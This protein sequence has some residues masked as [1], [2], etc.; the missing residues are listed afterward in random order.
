M[1]TSICYKTL[2]KI[3][4]REKMKRGEYK[5]KPRVTIPLVASYA[6]MLDKIK[7]TGHHWAPTE[8]GWAQERIT[9]AQYLSRFSPGERAEILGYSK[10][11]QELVSLEVPTPSAPAHN[12]KGQTKLM[13]ML[14]A[15]SPA[16][17]EQ[18]LRE[19]LQKQGS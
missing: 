7:R 9:P 12:G 14:K 10:K 15:L 18:C 13:D 16:E 11:L 6:D 4:W 5:Q 17:R 8:T 1:K 19:A 3:Y 2:W